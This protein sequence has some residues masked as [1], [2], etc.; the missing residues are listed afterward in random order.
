[1]GT[2]PSGREAP[3]GQGGELTP[4]SGWGGEWAVGS[5]LEAP[6]EAGRAGWRAL[7]G[8]RDPGAQDGRR[9][10]LLGGCGGSRG[11]LRVAGRGLESG[12]AVADTERP[13]GHERV[14][15]IAFIVSI[16]VSALTWGLVFALRLWWGPRRAKNRPHPE[17]QP[18]P[19]R[20]RRGSNE[21]AR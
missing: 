19:I 15:A 5:S 14:R 6:F 2:G 3:L 9:L 8:W 10:G 12:R 21:D 17:L 16:A 4:R 13:L 20:R 1:M 11:E 7:R 18:G